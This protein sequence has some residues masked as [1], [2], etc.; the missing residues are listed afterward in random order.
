MFLLGI[1]Y[2]TALELAS[3]GCRVIIADI[4]DAEDAKKSII[5]KTN[6]T[7]IAV[8]RV[9]LADLESVRKFANDINKT[10]ERL[11]ILINNAGIGA[12]KPQKTKD[13]LD[14]VTQTNYFGPFL[15]THL[16]AGKCVT[17]NFRSSQEDTSVASPHI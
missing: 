11:D 15:L 3:R 2:F 9:D 16:L 14:L 5:R 10:E 13:G 4:L 1:G 7:N 12:R 8:K 17:N 6:N